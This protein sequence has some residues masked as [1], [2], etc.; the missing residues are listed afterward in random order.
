VTKRFNNKNNKLTIIMSKK[1][2]LFLNIYSSILKANLSW[3]PTWAKFCQKI[4]S[5]SVVLF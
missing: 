5:L 3:K 1:N 2:R 4:A